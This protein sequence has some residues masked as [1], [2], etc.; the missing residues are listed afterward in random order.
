MWTEMADPSNEL[1]QLWNLQAPSGREDFRGSYL[2]N[3]AQ[4]LKFQL[5]FDGVTT[6][7]GPPPYMYAL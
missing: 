2:W 1:H 6:P 7:M 5:S 4:S 3:V